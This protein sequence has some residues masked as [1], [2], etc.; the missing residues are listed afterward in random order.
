MK[1]K[2]LITLFI[3]LFIILMILSGCHSGLMSEKN[4]HINATSIQGND[5]IYDQLNEDKFKDQGKLAFILKEHL[6]ILNGTTGEIMQINEKGSPLYPRWSADGNY[7]AFVM[8]NNHEDMNGTLWVA[9]SDGSQA[10]KIINLKDQYSVFQWSPQEDILAVCLTDGI[11]LVNIDGHDRRLIKTS[12]TC[13]VMWSPDGKQLAY[14]VTLPYD[15]N[16]PELRSDAMYSVAI[17]SGKIVKQ[18]E[19][20]EAGIQIA[21]WWSDS[22]G[23]LFW[24]D[25]CHSCSI[26]ADGLDL[27][28]LPLGEQNPIRLGKGLSYPDYLAQLP[29]HQLI[30]VAGTGRELYTNKHLEKID[31]ITGKSLPAAQAKGSVVSDLALSDDGKQLAYISARDTEGY[32]DFSDKAVLNNWLKTFTLMVSRADGSNARALPANGNMITDP[33]WSND[34]KKIVYISGNSLW[35]IDVKGKKPEKLVDALFK[36]NADIPNTSL[37]AWYR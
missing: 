16:K 14:S 12:N 21:G 27:Y 9:K 18:A 15:Q 7:L 25:P 26:A 34:G 33:Q 3:F 36:D 37:Y 28:S 31:L 17:S 10:R 4:G 24:V 30:M 8:S 5:K 22:N 20:N 35:I 23:L 29:S 2:P 6:Y 1:R 32:V 19:E 13:G 11:H